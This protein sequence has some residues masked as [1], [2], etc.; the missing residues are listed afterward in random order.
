MHITTALTA[1]VGVALLAGVSPATA[2][3]AASDEGS[4]VPYARGVAGSPATTVDPTQ[5][6]TSTGELQLRGLQLRD[7]PVRFTDPRLSGTLTIWSNGTGRVFTD[8]HAR[9]EPRTYRIDNGD[10]AWAGTG[11]RVL[12]VSVR[13]PR[14]LLNHESMVLLGEGAYEGL[15]AYVFIELANA[16]PELQAVVLDVELAP[17]PAP[18]A[19][20]ERPRLEP[21]RRARNAP[22]ARAHR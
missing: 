8:G 14:P 12:A 3:D 13:Q 22:M 15:V 17:T 6:Q 1:L 4:T 10:G 21:A 19:A 16:V 20:P 9:I 5:R 18:V 2:Q 11:E 7:I